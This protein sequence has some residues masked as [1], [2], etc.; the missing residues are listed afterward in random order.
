MDISRIEKRNTGADIIR[1]VAIFTVISVHFF[2][3]NG[4]YSEIVTGNKMLIMCIMRTLFGV[5]VPLFIL[6]TGYLMSQKTLSRKYYLGIRKTLVIY[7]LASFACMIYRVSYLKVEFTFKSAFFE[8]LSFSGAPYSWYIEMY[9][10]LFLLIPFLNIVYN[11]L[12]NKKQKQILI[13]TMICLTILP[14]LFNI[15]NFD[16]AQWWANPASST[17]YTKIIPAW[18][19]S[20]YP[21]TYYFVGC[22]LHEYGLKIKTKTMLLLFSLCTVF[23]GIF[24]FYRSYGTKYITGSYGFWYGFQPFILSILLF[25]MLSRIKGT[26]IP[27]KGKFVL[28][29]ISDLALSM[30]LVSYIFDSY[31][32]PKLTAAVPVMT[33]RLGYYFIMVPLVFICSMLLSA[34][35]AII[36][37]LIF[38]GVPKLKEI[39]L[40]IKNDNRISLQ[41]LLFYLLLLGAVMFAFWKC[42]Y[43]F[44]GNDEAFYLTTAHR[45]SLGDI[46]IKDEWH[47]SQFSGFLLLPIVSLY[48]MIMGSTEGIILTMRFIYVIFHAAITIFVYHRLRNYGYIT[49]FASILYFI[50]TPFDIMALSYNTMA[51]DL[52]VITGILIATTGS[53]KR[54]GFIV[55]GLT[56][57]GAVLCS[58]YLAIVYLLYG[59]CVI[60]HIILKKKNN[61][62]SIFSES[63]F[64]GKTFLCFTCG[65]LILAAIFLIFL[66]SQISFSDIVA[67]LPGMFTD[68]EHP[69]IE[70]RRK[71]RLL[72]N[73]I[74]NCHPYFFIAMVSYGVMLISMIAD[75]DRKNHRSFYFICSCIIT[76]YCYILFVPDLT[77][78]YY[79]ALI[80]PMIFIGLTSYILCENKPKKLLASMFILGILYAFCVSYGSNQY[81]YAISM[82]TAITN[83]SSM[84][85][86]GILLK[87]MKSRKDNVAYGKL[88]AKT[89]FIAMAFT[90]SLLGFLQIKVKA[91]HCFWETGVTSTLTSE[92]K[93]GPAK[94]IYTNQANA[95]TYQSLY[96]DLQY[97]KGKTPDNILIL[98]EKTWCYLNLNNFPY[99]TLSAWLPENDS[100]LTRLKSY[101]EINPNK[102]PVYIYIPK[103]SKLDVSSIVATAQ[104]YGYE[105]EENNVSYKL[106]RKM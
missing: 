99:G 95:D 100:T 84:I 77:Y 26:K 56:F 104:S 1:I 52:L 66:F 93:S 75:S 79:N 60:I 96:S 13:L 42:L 82:A 63:I 101:Y 76:V 7:L 9:I 32:Y 106:T 53:K 64:C 46:F 91:N 103:T 51:L 87:E 20:L 80:F 49:V 18:W 44:E 68:P 58:P 62:H 45:L 21:V 70:F 38:I 48:K 16:N 15:Y 85:F 41:T 2:L 105:L 3:N 94:G 86:A 14:S 12:E 25:T 98:S 89:S 54:L 92:I 19:I 28:W 88:L 43:G 23:F 17:E 47:L 35:L 102:I 5:C 59:I 55:S 36:E 57:A 71:I 22:Y 24:N 74:Y 83:I 34:L 4:F 40:S 61:T 29:K 50:F 97:Y 27:A 37:K 69:H 81:F 65:I 10:G 6:L 67:N 90:I 30:Y 78:K 39:F 8:I 33:D 73:S 72:W 11:K 31:F